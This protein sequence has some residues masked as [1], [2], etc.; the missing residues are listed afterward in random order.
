[1][2]GTGPW[3]FFVE[4]KQNA[5][6]WCKDGNRRGKIHL[7]KVLFVECSGICRFCEARQSALPLTVPLVGELGYPTSPGLSYNFP[8]LA[9]LQ[10]AKQMAAGR[11]C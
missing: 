10:V 11:G 6:H 5:P 9:G 1:M 7:G 8:L 2:P 3:H 4:T